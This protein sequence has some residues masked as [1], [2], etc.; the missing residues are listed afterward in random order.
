MYLDVSFKFNKQILREHMDE[1][2][3]KNK[4][5]PI[6][7]IIGGAGP[8]ACIDIQKKLSGL[9]KTHCN[10]LT[11]QE[12]F[13][14][15]VDNN[16]ALQNRDLS[17]QKKDNTLFQQLQESI[18]KLEQFGV[19][20]AAIACNSA[21]IHFSE[22]QKNTR[23]YLVN[24]IEVTADKLHKNNI[25]EVVLL[26]TASSYKNQLYANAFKKREII[27]HLANKNQQLRLSKIIYAIKAG[28][29]YTQ[30]TNKINLVYTYVNAL[31]NKESHA[32]E[33]EQLSP[34]S[35]LFQDI[36]N[37][38]YQAGCKDV[39]LGCTELPLLNEFYD[40]F[41]GMQ[42]HDPNYFLAEKMIYMAC[43]YQPPFFSEKLTS[44]TA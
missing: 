2:N 15:F 4:Y 22:L 19:N 8:D 31:L 3:I 41:V 9:M 25:K 30:D 33:N 6:L 11:D 13:R 43:Q 40:G 39:V 5:P 28:C 42:F 32:F 27:T 44:V 38:I 37:E 14:V 12:H 34:P 20:I 1:L 10:A 17:S 24:M 18:N 21:H 35:K 29:F 36:I 7:G 16:T 26:C 23:I